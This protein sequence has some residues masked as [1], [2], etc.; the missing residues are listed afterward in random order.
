[1]ATIGSLVIKLQAETKALRT[2][3]GKARREIRTFSTRTKRQLSAIDRG[4][5]ALG[6]S[7]KGFLGLFVG[8]AA[9]RGIDQTLQTVSDLADTADKLGVTTDALQELRFAGEQTGVAFTTTDMAIQ[10]FTR[11]IGEAAQGG[12]ELKGTL[13]QYNIAVT[14]AKDRT[15]ATV[16]VLDDLADVIRDADSDAERLRIGFKAFDSEGV[17]LVN[18]LRDGRQG[19]AEWSRAAAAA[20]VVMDSE[21]I[22]R[23]REINREWETFAALVSTSAKTRL[24][25]GIVALRE[26]AEMAGLVS[27][28]TQAASDDLLET[29][30]ELSGLRAEADQL[31]ASID[32]LLGGKTL[33]DLS[34]PPV[35][36]LEAADLTGQ[37]RELTIQ[38]GAVESRL[39]RLRREARESLEEPGGGTTGTTTPLTPEQLQAQERIKAVTEELRF[40]AEQVQRTAQV[41]RVYNEIRRAGTIADSEA[42]RTIRDLVERLQEAER[43]Q[44]DMVERTKEIEVLFEATRTPLER[45]SAEIER[46][47]QLFD[48]GRENPEIYAR[49]VELAAKRFEQATDKAVDLE[50]VLDRGLGRALSGSM[51]DW[52]AWGRFAI[53]Q[54][55]DVLREMIRVKAASQSGGLGGFLG[56]ALGIVGG[57]F[58]AGSPDPISAGIQVAGGIQT[59]ARGTQFTVGG[60]GGTDSQL[61]QIKTTPRELV[62]VETPQQVRA[63]EEGGGA[64]GITVINHITVTGEEAGSF[65]NAQRFAA[66]ISASVKREILQDMSDGGAFA[67]GSGRRA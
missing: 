22:Q 48:S 34:L 37:L 40:Q 41:Q 29:G 49:A 51:D 42:G 64:G 17:A 32:A 59:A 23:T 66:A 38:I 45:Y 3:L 65:A 60:S 50:R 24:L 44:D 7:A 39:R 10:R 4:F 67:V 21:L 47:N 25:E 5:A 20:G 43:A 26:L 8:G 58:G 9:L 1:M 53:D 63:R 19:L 28:S 6:R 62:T 30:A 2:D 36:R 55:R 46:L 54:L 31:R 35:T 57:L 15:R 18:V 14:D 61:T 27:L 16:D 12:G 13:D 33:D 11:R 56:Q 52:Q